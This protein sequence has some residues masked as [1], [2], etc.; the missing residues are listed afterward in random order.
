MYDWKTRAHHPLLDDDGDRVP[1]R[2]GPPAPLRGAPEGWLEHLA[3]ARF[4]G[5]SLVLSARIIEP[6][7]AS[8]RLEFVLDR[9]GNWSYNGD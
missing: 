5:T 3:V 6:I 7:A 8:P 9:G 1:D 4:E 2:V